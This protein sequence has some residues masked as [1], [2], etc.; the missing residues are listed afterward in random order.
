MNNQ[1]STLH[2]QK[3]SAKKAQ[4]ALPKLGVGCAVLGT[5]R[6]WTSFIG[7]GSDEALDA[8]HA[9]RVLDASVVQV[10]FDEDSSVVLQ[11]FAPDGWSAELSVPLDGTYELGAQ[12]DRL[13][14]DLVV[15]KLASSKTAEQLRRQ[16]V[17]SSSER[18]DWL[19]SHGIEELFR[20]P[21]LRP[22]PV[23][24]TEDRVRELAPDA[25]LIRA[26]G[27]A[28][29]KDAPPA[30][31]R[32]KTAPTRAWSARE[33]AVLDLHFH[34]LTQL[35]NMND[36]KVYNRYKK[37]LP[38]QRRREVDELVNLMMTGAS[39]DELRRALEGIL[40]TIWDADDWNAV[41]RDPQLLRHEPL[42]TNQLQDWQHRLERAESAQE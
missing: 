25:Q 33:R 38:A 41:I 3:M 6:Q 11:I 1:G 13:L 12:D 36:W 32:E 2:V 20:F 4:T 15:R 24:C 23:P 16:L 10:W 14:H 40:G 5:N 35:W 27:R 8:A 39:E 21:F 30:A 28:T 31:S 34:Y 19:R 22:L 42:A 26:G 29:S 7:L 18:E 17:R 37:H 9:A